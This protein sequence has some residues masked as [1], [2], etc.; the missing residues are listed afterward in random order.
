MNQVMIS[1]DKEKNFRVYTALTTE[2]VEKMRTTHQTTPTASAALGRT[3]TCA[4]MMGLMLKGD[5]SKITIIIKGD[6]SAGEILSVAN[7]KGIVKGYI[8]N[9]SVDL[10]LNAGKLDVGTAVGK[11]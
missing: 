5:K 2:M 11:G 4:S 10:P 9:P 7:S 8:Q 6:G 3:I 1:I